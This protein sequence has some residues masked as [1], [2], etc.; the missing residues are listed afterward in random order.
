VPHLRINSV[1][2]S[3]EV[4]PLRGEQMLVGR[5]RECDLVLPDVL[6]SRRHAELF[7]TARGWLVRDLGSM[8]GTR[9]NDERIEDERVLYDGDVVTVGGWRLVFSE[10]DPEPTPAHSSDH[11]AR[12]HDITSLATRSGLD[13]SDLTRQGRLLGVLTRAAGAIVATPN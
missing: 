1:E 9:V 11:E 10:A 8:N 2:G 7:C 12:V 3:G 4:L 13:L 6:L 5:S